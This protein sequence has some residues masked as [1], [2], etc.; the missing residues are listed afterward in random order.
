[1]SGVRARSADDAFVLRDTSGA[2][3]RLAPDRIANAVQG[4]VSLMPEGLLSALSQDEI[5]DLLAYLQS[6]R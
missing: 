4:K 5:R 3:V 1:M 2:D 6:L